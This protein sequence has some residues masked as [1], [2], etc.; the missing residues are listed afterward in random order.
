VLYPVFGLL[1]PH[2]RGRG[3]ELQL[4]LGDQQCAASAHRKSLIG[5]LRAR[6]A[7]K[8]SL[9]T[10]KVLAAIDHSEASEAVIKEIAARPW[11]PKSSIEV[12]NVLEHAHLWAVSET[13]EEARQRS[14]DLI[15]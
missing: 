14:T 6:A 7:G 11:P 1:L 12:L 4:G 2:D 13:A 10:M 5:S 3:D 9:D 8:R 15:H